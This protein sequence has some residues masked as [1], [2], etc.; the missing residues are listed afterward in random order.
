MEQNNSGPDFTR[1]FDWQ[2]NEERKKE[3]NELKEEFNRLKEEKKSKEQFKKGEIPLAQ[4]LLLLHYTGLLNKIDQTTKGKS[5]LL[6]KVLNRSMDNIR[7]NLTYINSP[8]ITDSKIKNVEN[9]EVILNIFNDLS[10]LEVADK[11]KV[12]LNKIKEI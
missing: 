7:K 5:L 8:R 11:V 1:I 9:L 4:Q 12:D 2:E 6:S 10:M 3:F